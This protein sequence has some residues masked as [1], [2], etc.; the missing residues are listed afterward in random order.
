MALEKNKKN[1]KALKLSKL[2]STKEKRPHPDSKI[3]VTSTASQPELLPDSTISV[4]STAPSKKSTIFKRLRTSLATFDS[5]T[6]HRIIERRRQRNDYSDMANVRIFSPSD[7]D[8]DK[9]SSSWVR[10]GDGDAFEILAERPMSEWRRTQ[11]SLALRIAKTRLKDS[12]QPQR[13]SPRSPFDSPTK[14][15]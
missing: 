14:S 6:R 9:S 1:D 4:T 10:R 8:E 15:K 5:P 11:M 12:T 7:N 13:K 2:S 3:S